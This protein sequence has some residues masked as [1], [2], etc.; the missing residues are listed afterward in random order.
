MSVAAKTI[1]ITGEPSKVLSIADFSAPEHGAPV[2]GTAMNAAGTFAEA[3]DAH[4]A[5]AAGH[6][7]GWFVVTVP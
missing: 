5:R 6:V 7:A 4:A 3:A 2:S 1:A